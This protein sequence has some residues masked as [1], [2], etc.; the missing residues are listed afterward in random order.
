MSAKSKLSTEIQIAKSDDELLREC[1]VDTF[2]SSGPGGQHVNKTESGVRL[3]HIPTGIVVTSR[4]ERSQ[5]RNKARC[6]QELRR[7]IEKL[8][9]RPAKRI[10]T[11]VPRGVKIKT[12]EEKARRSKVKQLRTKP[13]RDD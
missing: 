8:N 5:F 1:K 9:H 3:K 7:R 2:R 12:L 4:V 11:N 10:R 13:R 6:L